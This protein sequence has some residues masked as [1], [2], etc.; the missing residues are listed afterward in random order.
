MNK[1]L[2]IVFSIAISDTFAL[3]KAKVIPISITDFSYTLRFI[4]DKRVR[5]DR[6]SFF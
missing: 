3:T 1:L 6:E 5:Y 4:E 2:D